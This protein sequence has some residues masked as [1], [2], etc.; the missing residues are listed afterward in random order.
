MNF[1]IRVEGQDGAKS[2]PLEK[3]LEKGVNKKTWICIDDGSENWDVAENVRELDS[4]W[5]T[6]QK[7]KKKL[8]RDIEAQMPIKEN[9]APLLPE[10][11]EEI[12]EPS[13]ISDQSKNNSESTI[14]TESSQEPVS[15]NLSNMGLW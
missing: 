7:V 2:V 5:E 12:V 8:K 1:Y 9:Q 6:E 13:I 10:F 14:F 11:E 4:L 15:N 3:L